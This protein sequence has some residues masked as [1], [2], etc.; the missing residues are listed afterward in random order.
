MET[1]NYSNIGKHQY[2]SS[3]QP[4][5]NILPGKPFFAKIPNLTDKLANVP[6]FIMVISVSI[7]R[8]YI[9]HAWVA[10]P[11]LME[12]KGHVLMRYYKSSTDT[13]LNV[14]RYKMPSRRD[15]HMNRHKAV[16]SQD[17]TGDFE[18]RMT[19]RTRDTNEYSTYLEKFVKMLTKSESIWDG[20]F[21]SI[22]VVK[23]RIDLEKAYN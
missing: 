18:N 11:D 10:E 19:R 6:K 17:T 9:I 8:R 3:G 2:Y 14:A 20:H 7:A 5:M 16:K 4:R 12:S 21:G 15:E 23:Y 22:E 1:A 13:T